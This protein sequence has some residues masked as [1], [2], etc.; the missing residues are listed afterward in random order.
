MH[1]YLVALCRLLQ[2]DARFVATESA[3]SCASKDGEGAQV[4][5]S[6]RDTRRI[7]TAEQ[8]YRVREHSP[9]PTEQQTKK[10]NLLSQLSVVVRRLECPAEGPTVGGDH[11]VDSRLHVQPTSAGQVHGVAAFPKPLTAVPIPYLSRG[12]LGELGRP[13]ASFRA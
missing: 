13:A 7:S 1:P 11:L 5:Q 4:D 9:A 10:E 12:V 2:V 3:D 6:K 8:S